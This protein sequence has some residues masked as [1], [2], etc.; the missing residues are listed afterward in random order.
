MADD[1]YVDARS[2]RVEMFSAETVISSRSTVLMP[3]AQTCAGELASIGIAARN[4]KQKDFF[5]IIFFLNATNQKQLQEHPR[6]KEQEE[7]EPRVN[8]N[9]Y[10]SC[11][12]ILQFYK[13]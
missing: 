10:D 7:S 6:R 2:V 8:K 9:A 11:L 3:A 12:Q 13:I 4:A 5:V 1:L